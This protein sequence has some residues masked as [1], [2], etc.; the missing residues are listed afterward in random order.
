M[1]QTTTRVGIVAL[2]VLV[3]LMGVLGNILTACDG[4]LTPRRQN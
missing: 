1:S 2:G 4:S 3:G